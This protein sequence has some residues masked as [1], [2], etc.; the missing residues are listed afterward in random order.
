MLKS[1]AIC[2]FLFVLLTGLSGPV[3][4]QSALLTIDEAALINGQAAAVASGYYFNAGISVIPQITVKGNGDLDATSGGGNPIPIGKFTAA[5]INGTTTGNAVTLTTSPQTVTGSLLGLVLLSSGPFSMKY[6]APD[7]AATAWQAG[8]YTKSL[9]MGLAG[10]N[11]LASVTPETLNL[12]VDVPAF[13]KDI[14]V[15]VDITLQVNNLNFFR[16]MPLETQVGIVLRHTVPV[17]MN[18]S[19]NTAQFAFSNGYNGI[20]DPH[21]ATGKVQLQLLSPAGPVMALSSSAQQLVANAP[22]TA[23]NSTS[24]NTRFFISASDLKSSFINKGNYTTTLTL[25][26]SNAS[27]LAATYSKLLNLTVAVSDLA[28]LNLGSSQVNLVFQTAADYK[29]GVTADLTGHLLVSKTTPYDVSVKAQT[30][31]LTSGTGA[32]IPVSILRIGPASGQTGVAT[33][34]ALSTT[35]QVLVSAA[36]PVVDRSFDIR[37]QIPAGQ[38]A[39]LINKPGGIYTGTVIYTLTAH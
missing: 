16:N 28:E 8:S 1:N 12:T 17:K 33:V 5:A 37:Y 21:A 38:T 7:L 22:L 31:E 25:Q 20:A 36:A 10:I 2:S 14:N 9:T 29:N 11:L 26:G 4:A 15:P 23:G 34:N 27:G 19:A 32:A 39:N 35:D 3:I 24:L 30:P 6:T 18:I 13:I